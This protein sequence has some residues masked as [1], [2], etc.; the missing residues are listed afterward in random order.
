MILGNQK[1]HFIVRFETY[2]D[3]LQYLGMDRECNR[4]TDR[5]TDRQNRL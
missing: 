5:Q 3:I 4:Q 2:F 1:H